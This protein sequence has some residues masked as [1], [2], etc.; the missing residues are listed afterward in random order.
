M[1]EKDVLTEEGMNHVIVDVGRRI[2]EE[3]VK[4]G[5]SMSRLAELANVST[6]HISK[7]ETAKCEIGLK[8]LI[9]IA[10]A[11]EMNA[12]DF[13]PEA[14]RASGMTNGGL[15]NGERFD[16]ITKGVSHK[17]VELA[18]KISVLLLDSI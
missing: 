16:L 7:V 11:L 14:E 17:K 12:S 18:L 6:S 8:S 4:R 1:E 5:M 13:L 3:R 9:K 15:T 10:T 2:K